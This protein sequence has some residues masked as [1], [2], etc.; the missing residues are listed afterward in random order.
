MSK[1]ETAILTAAQVRRSMTPD[2]DLRGDIAFQHDV[3]AL[4]ARVEQ[5]QMPWRSAS[6][7]SPAP[8]PSPIVSEA[9]PMPTVV[10]PSI[11]RLSPLV[12]TA[13]PPAARVRR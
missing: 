6:D 2:G 11:G 9:T 5:W 12:V 4:L 10:R 3:N 1:L 8:L 7:I 13:R